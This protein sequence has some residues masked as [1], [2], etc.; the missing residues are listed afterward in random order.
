MG[1]R[2]GWMQVCVAACPAWRAEHWHS[3]LECS[4]EARMV[5]KHSREGDPLFGY[6]CACMHA[7]EDS[8]IDAWGNAFI[9]AYSNSLQLFSTT[10]SA[11]CGECWSRDCIQDLSAREQAIPRAPETLQ[12]ALSYCLLYSMI[13]CMCCV[14]TES[15]KTSYIMQIVLFCCQGGW[16][17]ANLPSPG[18]KFIPGCWML[19]VS[20]LL[21]CWTTGEP[22]IMPGCWVAPGCGW[23]WVAEGGWCDLLLLLE[24]H[25]DFNHQSMS[26]HHHG[27]GV[28]LRSVSPSSHHLSMQV[29]VSAQPIVQVEDLQDSSQGQQP[30]VFEAALNWVHPDPW[31]FQAFL[32][33]VWSLSATESC[34]WMK[35][36]WWVW[37]GRQGTLQEWWELQQWFEK[38]FPWRWS[39]RNW[40]EVQEVRKAAA[41][42]SCPLH[43]VL[44]S[45]SS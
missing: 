45:W 37:K 3:V 20:T 13:P 19:R 1:E 25:P 44:L 2:E 21:H 33:H 35:P 15:W 17:D 4:T 24:V 10:G 7:R 22:C 11:R 34:H 42:P 9:T 41:S 14:Y 30:L 23:K 8:I 6:V 18:C 31:L 43:L 26:K 40:T 36:R 38:P 39:R 16:W 32:E 5:K 12:T 27:F 29:Y 28:A